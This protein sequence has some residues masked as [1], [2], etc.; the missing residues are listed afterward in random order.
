M[1]IPYF[2]DIIQSVVARVNN[3][4]IARSIDP[5]NV[6]FDKGLI[7]QVKRSVYNNQQ[8]DPLVWLVYKF[9]E[10]Y[11]IPSTT[12]LTSFQLVIAV[13]TDNKYTQQQREDINYKP[14]LLPVAMELVNEIKRDQW[15]DC[16]FGLGSS[17]GVG[18]KY[19]R[20]IS[21][22]YG[23][24]DVN[25]QDSNNLFMDRA[26]DAIFL[27]FTKLKINERDCAPDGDYYVPDVSQ[28][29]TQGTMLTFFDDLELIVG[30]GQDTDPTEGANSVIIPFLVGKIYSV[31]QRLIGTMR[32][33]RAVE[34]VPDLINGGFALTNG[35]T[36]IKNDTYII[37][38]QPKYIT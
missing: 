22:F 16:D 24:G 15:F 8:S 5:F 6:F 2:P 25:G 12:N 34:F 1:V 32:S 31:E 27:T 20:L 35:Q 36:F 26:Y 18:P 11:G 30:A 3:S 4:F 28:Y 38:I 14:R 10:D 21:P 7:E 9:A 37:K 17:I 13:P 23:M 29:P 33:R 19:Q